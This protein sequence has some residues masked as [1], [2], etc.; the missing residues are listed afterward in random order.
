[1]GHLRLLWIPGAVLGLIA[2][3]A[4]R[5]SA[6]L[7][8]YTGTFSAA[9]SS[10]GIPAEF[11]GSFTFSFDL[12]SVT[13]TGFEIFTPSL[14][15]LT[16]TSSGSLTIGNTTFDTS[17]TGINIVY[18]N[19]SFSELVIGGNLTGIDT[20]AAGTNDFFTSYIGSSI[21]GSKVASIVASSTIQNATLRGTFENGTISLPP[22]TVVPEPSTLGSG[23]LAAVAFLAYGWSRH[24]RE[25]RRQAAA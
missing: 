21:N 23:A 24:R 22:V 2:T 1:M 6:D 15:S 4:G 25:Q 3:T 17:N 18:I 8:T 10:S 20:V 9:F 14:S 5:A 19:G 13:G 11:S 7:L 16:P 12:S